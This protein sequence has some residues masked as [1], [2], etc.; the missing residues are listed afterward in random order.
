MKKRWIF[1]GLAVVAVLALTA[2]L[3]FAAGRGTGSG[4]ST[5]ATGWSRIVASCN[6]I[7]DPPAVAQMWAHMPAAAQAQ[8]EAMHEQMGRMMNGSGMMGGPGMMGG[9]GNDS[10]SGMMGGFG[11]DSDS[12]MMCGSH[13]SHHSGAFGGEVNRP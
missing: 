11:N 9:S 1:T 7:H 4:S 13:A 2:G 3:A 6:A 10:G 8:C 12:G 5:P